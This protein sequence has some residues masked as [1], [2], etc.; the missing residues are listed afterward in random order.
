MLTATISLNVLG[1]PSWRQEMYIVQAR[2][3]DGVVGVAL[4]ILAVVHHLEQIVGSVHNR[5]G[6]IDSVRHV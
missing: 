6:Q 4:E 5:L 2:S 1:T 3:G